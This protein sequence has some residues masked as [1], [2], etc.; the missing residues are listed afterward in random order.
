MPCACTAQDLAATAELEDLHEQQLSHA[1][2]LDPFTDAYATRHYEPRLP[3]RPHHLA[4]DLSFSIPDRTVRGRAT[5]TFTSQWDGA[6]TLAL[7]AEDFSS[8]V[9][10]SPNDDQVTHSYD[11]HMIQIMFSFPFSKGKTASVCVDYEVIDPIDGL[12][13]SRKGDGHFVVS[14]H[15]TERARYWIPVVD[16]PAVRTTISF[17]LR[18]MAA[19]Q[20]TALANG[21]LVSE[22]VEGEV[23]VTKW[24]MK[25][26]TPS[27]LLCVA[28]GKFLK[29]DGGKLK[30]KSLAFFAP[31]GGRRTYT[32]E[33]LA[34]TFGRTRE[35]IEFMENKVH[36]EMP[37]SKYYQWSCGEIG[38]AMENS[39]LVSYDEWYMLDERSTD[40]RS[41]RVDSTVVHELAHTWFGD[42]VVCSDFC[43]SFLKESFATLISAEW[44]HHKNGNDDFQYTLT[45]YAEAAFAET[46]E[47]MRP[48]VMRS[49]ET[50]W[51]MFDRHLYQNGA[52]RLHM[53]R[54]KLGD[55][56]FWEAVSSYLHKRSWKTVET[57]DFRRDIEEYSGE[58]LCSFFEQWFYS[59]GHPVLEASFSYDASKGG[60]ATVS[61]KQTQMDE[62]KGVGSFDLTVDIAMETSSGQWETHTITMENGSTTGQMFVKVGSKPLQVV[63]DPE[64]K[65]LHHLS[66]FSGVGDDLSLRSLQHAPTLAGRYQAMRLLHESGSKRALGGLRD[67]LRRELHWGLRSMIAQIL[68]RSSRRGS[69]PALFEALGTESEARVLPMIVWA[70]GEYRCEEAV[71]ALVKF[72][73]E[74][75]EMKRGYGCIGA[76]LRGIGKQRNLEHLGLLTEM[77]EQDGRSGPFE[78]G[79]AAAS[80]LGQ[81]RCSEA[82]EV[83]MRNVKEDDGSFCGRVRAAMVRGIGAGVAWEGIAGRMKAFEFV[84]GIVRDGGERLSVRE[85]AGAT[86][87][88]LGDAGKA[89]AALEELEK[90]MGN[91]SK[92]KARAWRRRAKRSANGR[93][94]GSRGDGV[95]W[96]RLEREVKDLKE[97]VEE[98][99]EK[100]DVCLGREV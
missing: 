88:G 69:L 74:G 47:Y 18:T 34:L 90:C 82:V 37:W 54:T 51:S 40:E 14:D 72:V 98:V 87:A 41:H 16:H 85:A 26:I 60:Y 35:M 78:I 57:D 42:T 94:G 22:E 24:E 73:Q 75:R 38:G 8:V 71:Q 58:Q 50:S 36:Y 77:L 79:A 81:L 99:R 3:L 28:I 89:E 44:Y 52:W 13:F 32:E 29:A 2:L 9:V 56:Q 15:E 53:L 70:V 31:V 1:S 23:K 61:V 66:K 30:G 64:K 7:N 83:L 20:L 97:K 48:I 84:E 59:K 6:R 17:T 43:H 21:E 96:E 25:Q 46:N 33:D 45:R 27:Y 63:L 95:G 93:E 67:A 55:M 65:V 12:L 39:S 49:Y 91:Q 19:E 68:G 5:H 92:I 86:L 11:G 62:K 100:V 4:L 10:S 80:A 76:A